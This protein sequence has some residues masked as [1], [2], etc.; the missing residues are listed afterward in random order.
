M[1]GYHCQNLQQSIIV[2][3]KSLS[4]LMLFSSDLNRLVQMKTNG[5]VFI[6]PN[7]WYCCF[8]DREIILGGQ[9]KGNGIPNKHSVFLFLLWYN[10]VNNQMVGV[11]NI[12]RNSMCG[13]LQ[14]VV[15]GS[16]FSF[17]LWWEVSPCF[18]LV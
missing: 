2:I 16:S 3:G 1:G 7:I 9:N 8:I 17:Q 12:Y 6:V 4:Q 10:S 11:N 5:R 14:V 15:G 18:C 13:V